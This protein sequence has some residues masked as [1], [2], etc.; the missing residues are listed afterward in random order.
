M[1]N[2]GKVIK[3]FIGYVVLSVLAFIFV[4]VGVIEFGSS[5]DISASTLAKQIDELL[6]TE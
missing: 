1:E 5:A 2:K 6:Q 4:V 3:L